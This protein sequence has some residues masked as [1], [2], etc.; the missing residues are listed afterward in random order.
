MSSALDSSR[1]LEEE[2]SLVGLQ[3]D[4]GR[5]KMSTLVD[6]Q[7]EHFLTLLSLLSTIIRI[8]STISR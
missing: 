8:S 7:I 2:L 3:P 5:L 4:D 6:S 1:A